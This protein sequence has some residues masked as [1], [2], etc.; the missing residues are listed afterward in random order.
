MKITVEESGMVLEE[1][2]SGIEMRTSEGNRIGI[3]MRDDTF[4]INILPK[5]VEGNN[6]WRVNMQTGKIENM[7]DMVKKIEPSTAMEGEVDMLLGFYELKDQTG[8]QVL[9][10]ENT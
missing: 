4:E 9:Q 8:K 10:G 3:C 5:G 6:W 2:Y 7:K 1:V